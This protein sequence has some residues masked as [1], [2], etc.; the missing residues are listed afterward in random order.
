MEIEEAIKII[1]ALKIT[2]APYR[3][4]AMETFDFAIDG[5]RELRHYRRIG[6]IYEF[7]K[8]LEKQIAKTPDYIGDGYADGQLVY[9]TWICPNCKND[10]EIGYDRYDYC[11]NC[12]QHIKHA[13]WERE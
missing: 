6:T 2:F 11:P 1:E 13:D 9:D 8:A 5:L 3:E 4:K 12:G 7:R 10:Y